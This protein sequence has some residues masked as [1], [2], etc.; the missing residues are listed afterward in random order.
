[1]KNFL[2]WIEANISSM[3]T[4]IPFVPPIKYPNISYTSAVTT[5]KSISKS[6]KSPIDRDNLVKAFKKMSYLLEK[7]DFKELQKDH[8]ATIHLVKVF[9]GRDAFFDVSVGDLLKIETILTEIETELF[10]KMNKEKIH[11]LLLQAQTI[12][13]F[14]KFSEWLQLR[15]TGTSTASVAVFARPLFSGPVVRGFSRKKRKK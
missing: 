6:L 12:L 10:G 8:A 9:S 11:Y 2:Q 3:P 13:T 14:S 4:V 5:K 1:M 15:E 7:N